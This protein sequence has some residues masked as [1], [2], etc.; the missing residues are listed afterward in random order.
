MEISGAAPE[1]PACKAG[2]LLVSLYP[3]MYVSA[4]VHRAS[5]PRKSMDMTLFPDTLGMDGF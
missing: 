5:I 2:S 4:P 1:T 3:L